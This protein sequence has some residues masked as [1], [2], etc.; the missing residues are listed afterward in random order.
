MQSASFAAS[1]YDVSR[2]MVYTQHPPIPL[3]GEAVSVTPAVFV[4]PPYLKALFQ[5]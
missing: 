1:S 4:H 2:L 3:K 5:E